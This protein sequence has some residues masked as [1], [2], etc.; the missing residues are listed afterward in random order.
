MLKGKIME[1]MVKCLGIMIICLQTIQS[2]DIVRED[3][4]CFERLI[5]KDEQGNVAHLEQ[6][7]SFLSYHFFAKKS[8]WR[9]K[10]KTLE[11][12]R[13]EFSCHQAFYAHFESL[14]L[15]QKSNK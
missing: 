12:L 7:K 9:F 14:F 15:K 4:G 2:I 3:K 1:L 8:E 5:V 11:E 13:K 10:G 6:C